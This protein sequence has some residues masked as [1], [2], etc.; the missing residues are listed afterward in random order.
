MTANGLETFFTK[1][2][3]FFGQ[4]KETKQKGKE[5][6]KLTHYGCVWK[7]CSRPLKSEYPLADKIIAILNRRLN[8]KIY[9]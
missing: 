5:R 9:D 3:D 4:F 8:N 2:Q 7:I 6:K 1:I